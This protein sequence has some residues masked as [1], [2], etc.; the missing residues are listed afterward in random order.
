MLLK[1]WGYLRS[2]CRHI[3]NAYG[4]NSIEESVPQANVCKVCKYMPNIHVCVFC[5]HIIVPRP[6][7]NFIIII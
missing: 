1:A 6:W 7:E 3:L 5:V 2:H 4:I